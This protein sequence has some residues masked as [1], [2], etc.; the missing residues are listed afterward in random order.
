MVDGLLRANEG[1]KRW[2]NAA[3]FKWDRR[4]LFVVCHFRRQ[5]T[6]NDGLP[7]RNLNSK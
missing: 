7:H 3:W 6:K 1:M 2:I 5:T 4:S